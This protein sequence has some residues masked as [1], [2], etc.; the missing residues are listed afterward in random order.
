MDAID[1]THAASELLAAGQSRE[2]LQSRAP[3]DRRTPGFNGNRFTRSARSSNRWAAPI[4]RFRRK[5]R[6]RLAA[7]E[8]LAAGQPREALQTP[9]PRDHRTPG[10]MATDSQPSA[11]AL[12]S[13]GRPDQAFPTQDKTAPRRRSLHSAHRGRQHLR[14]SAI[15]DAWR[16]FVPNCRGSLGHSPQ[17]NA[18]ITGIGGL[19]RRAQ[20]VLFN[21]ASANSCAAFVSHRRNA[22]IARIG[23]LTPE[24]SVLS[25][26]LRQLCVAVRLRQAGA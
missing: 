2:A 11:R 21:Q 7:S 8:L 5:T 6:L 13:L 25:V 9:R 17:R 22:G 24:A 4:R 10:S 18:G 15:A 3:R 12:E 16:E 19:W 23:G 1:L 20:S 14:G 26:G